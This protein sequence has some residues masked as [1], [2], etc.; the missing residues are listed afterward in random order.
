M[1]THLSYFTTPYV[2]ALLVAR[3]LRIEQTHHTI[4]AQS[5]IQGVSSW[6]PIKIDTEQLIRL[7][8]VDS[9]EKDRPE[10]RNLEW[11]LR[12][13]GG[14]LLDKIWQR[15]RRFVLEMNL[16]A[17]PMPFGDLMELYCRKVSKVPH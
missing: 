7:G 1:F 9:I 4:K 11:Q 2:D 12:N 14:H 17:L 8:R 10:L 13:P 15:L 16:A 3:G 5:L 6:L